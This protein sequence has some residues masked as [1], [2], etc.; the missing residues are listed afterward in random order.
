M[1]DKEIEVNSDAPLSHDDLVDGLVEMIDD[2]L[3]VSNDA[4][5]KQ[6]PKAEEETPEESDDDYL[7][8]VDSD[9]EEE[10]DTPEETSEADDEEESD[11]G[12]SEE[13]VLKV[14]GEEITVTMDEL[15]K[16]YS[17]QSDYTKKTQEL[18]EQRKAIEE[19]V[20]TLDYLRVYRDLQPDVIALQ[21]KGQEIERAV[22]AIENG[23]IEEEDGTLVQLTP[24][25]VEGTRR[26]VQDAE[27]EYKYEQARI[28]KAAQEMV[29]PRL[30]E[31]REKAPDLFSEDAS[32]RDPM[33]QKIRGLRE[34][35]GFS[36]VEIESENDP[37]NILR[38]LEL[39]E[40]RDLKA[41]V[42]AAKARKEKSS[43]VVSK[44][45]KSSKRTG[46]TTRKSDDSS[47]K[48]AKAKKQLESG[49]M[50]D[51]EEFLGDLI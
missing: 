19:E 21:R 45:T 40:L 9:D 16:G 12:D 1:S 7:A 31:L 2:N 11:D 47:S 13:V 49:E 50:P 41:R 28:N 25:E 3:N 23:Y 26:N 36:S 42:E 14:D 29:P 10:V 22:K 39:L 4:P 27:R 44:P 35:F 33:L 34:E 6:Q 32:V 37:R 51:M 20:K 48:M 8:D 5:V 46:T 17:R 24:E 18:A 38:D 30:D 43:G 15:K